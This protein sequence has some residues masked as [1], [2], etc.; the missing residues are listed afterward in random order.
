MFSEAKRTGF[1]TQAAHGIFGVVSISIIGEKL[2]QRPTEDRYVSST[3]KR[4]ETTKMRFVERNILRQRMESGAL[5]SDAE[6][7][8][9]AKEGFERVHL[10]EKIQFYNVARG[11]A[12]EVASQAILAL[13]SP[14][15][16]L[17]TSIS[18]QLR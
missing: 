7:T 9:Q 14:I 1:S 17:L 15:S 2:P 10:Q 18:H 16:Y 13:F 4:A 6:I 11:S 5:R 12:G 8:S 3:T